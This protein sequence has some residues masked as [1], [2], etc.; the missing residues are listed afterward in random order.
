MQAAATIDL[1]RLLAVAADAAVPE[2][3]A[4]TLFPAMPVTPKAAIAVAMDQAFNFYYP[5]ALDLLTAWGAELVPF[6]LLED[7]TLPPNASGV[8]IGGGFPEIFAAPLA[9]NV[10]MRASIRAA[11][12]RRLPIYAECGGLMYLCQSLEDLEGRSYAMAGVFPGRSVLKGARLT[13][14]YRTIRAMQSNCLL[15]AGETVRGHEFHFSSVQN[16]P[17][18]MPL[19]YEVLDQPGRREG[20]V[21]QNV[22]ASYMHIHLGSKASLAPRFVATCARSR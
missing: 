22:L 3:Q 1:D 11:A 16:G 7:A 2:A 9:D 8:Y 20:F 6:S 14:G 10:S 4:R 18:A 13:L 19:A 5:D 17:A 12:E 21:V 15:V